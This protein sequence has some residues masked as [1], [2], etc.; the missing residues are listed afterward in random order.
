MFS[1]KVHGCY[2]VEH[3]N[4][5]SHD[6][7]TWS[8]QIS[9]RTA[10]PREIHDTFIS[11]ASWT[12]LSDVIQTWHCLLDLQLFSAVWLDTRTSAQFW[13]I[14]LACIV[15]AQ[16]SWGLDLS[17]TGQSLT[18]L[19]KCA[20]CYPISVPP[21]LQLGPD[22]CSL[23]HLPPPASSLSP[24]VLPT[25]QFSSLNAFLCP[26]T[27][28]SLP[29]HPSSSVSSGGSEG[30]ALWS[31]TELMQQQMAAS[32]LVLPEPGHPCRGG[33]T[34]A[35]QLQSCSTGPAC[36]T[37]SWARLWGAPENSP[38][39]AAWKHLLHTTEKQTYYSGP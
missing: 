27:H 37:N 28:L 39:M 10:L 35:G 18:G 33:D 25:T 32:E 22:G 36:G 8:G 13:W 15:A 4:I 21:S 11:S 6:L 9:Q 24:P 14:I 5:I 19:G 23:Q 7:K 1:L 3:Y 12:F 29:L 31:S 30:A 26:F 2:N 16:C 20:T 34:A 38:W 17:Q